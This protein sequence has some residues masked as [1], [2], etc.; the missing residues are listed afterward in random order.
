M[1]VAYIAS[2]FV[3][4]FL[5]GLT[6]LGGGSIMTPLLVLVFSVKPAVAVGTDLIYA[7][8]TKS[9][10]ILAHQSR[11]TIEWKIVRLLTI[12]SI[13]A[14]IV[15][16]ACLRHMDKIG[17]Q[18]DAVIIDI[19]GIVLIA[20][21][22]LLLFRNKLI[23]L[24]QQK[25]FSTVRSIHPK[26]RSVMTVFAG[27]MIGSLVTFSSVGAGVL[28]TAILIL[29]YPRLPATNIIGTDLVHAVPVTT[30]AGMGH[31]QLGTVDFLLLA[32]LLLGSLPGIYLGNLSGT[33]LPDKFV[34]SL[35]ASMLFVIGILFVTGLRISI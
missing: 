11:G 22:L 3:V 29:L 24:S 34:R 32:N 21:S 16:I 5:I 10:G 2:G 7:A 19:L 17:F 8:V 14:T 13:P 12:G 35:L 28:G 33:I 27:A 15:S 9:G 20:T 30:I 23:L 26:Y 31:I 25:H 1:S 4:S 18:V 6:G